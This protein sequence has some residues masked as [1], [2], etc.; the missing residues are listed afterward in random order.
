MFRR[1]G[2]C[3][4]A[5]TCWDSAIGL[6]KAPRI[7]AGVGLP[8]ARFDAA[9]R[10]SMR[11]R[12]CSSHKE[13][14]A[15]TPG[16]SVACLTYP[17]AS[18][19][20]VLKSLGCSVRRANVTCSMLSSETVNLVED[21][22]GVVLPTSPGQHLLVGLIRKTDVMFITTASTNGGIPERKLKLRPLIRIDN[23]LGW[24]REILANAL[25]GVARAI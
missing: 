3:C 13:V 18:G 1:I 19:R 2:V 24:A 22:K 12:S 25:V 21:H 4:A 14:R 23:P 16:S 10:S 6:A 7:V 20:A 8:S 15:A 5:G 9:T 17:Y 11:M